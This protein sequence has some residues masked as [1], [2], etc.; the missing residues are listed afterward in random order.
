MRKWTTVIPALLI[1]FSNSFC[2]AA[3]V[4][5]P[6]QGELTDSF[7]DDVD[8]YDNV[9][10]AGIADLGTAE[11][12]VMD[13]AGIWQHTASLTASDGAGVPRYDGI[14]GLLRG[15]PR[16]LL[17]GLRPGRGRRRHGGAGRAAGVGDR[18]RAPRRHDHRR[19]PLA[20]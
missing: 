15:Q 13:S 19:P 7:I 8:M 12:Y 2:L 3:P 20:A 18:R 1:G 17:P 6:T 4:I 11:I 10:I 16:R 9:A 5:Y 14:E